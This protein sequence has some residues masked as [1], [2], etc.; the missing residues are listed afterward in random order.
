MGESERGGWG[1]TARFPGGTTA[2]AAAASDGGMYQPKSQR[3]ETPTTAAGQDGR[4]GQPWAL[5]EMG[6]RETAG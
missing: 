3:G 1:D 4:A 2:H 5:R 6:P